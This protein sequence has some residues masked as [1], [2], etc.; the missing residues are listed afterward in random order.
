MPNP[1]V[2]LT[3]AIAQ[4]HDRIIYGEVVAPAPPLATSPLFISMPDWSADYYFEVP[5]WPM[6]HGAALPAVGAAVVLVRDSRGF[7]R[8]VWWDGTTTSAAATAPAP[9]G[10]AAKDTAAINALLATGAR[11]VLQPGTYQT[12]ASLAMTSHSSLIG[13]GRNATT[14]KKNGNYPT[15]TVYGATSVTNHCAFVGISDLTLDGNGSA[16]TGPH[17]DCVY[18]DNVIVERMELVSN[19]D[20][21]IDMVELW[22][23]H[24]NDIVCDACN[25]TSA[26]A[27]H[28]RSSRAASGFG[29]SGDTTNVIRFTNIRCESWRNGGI[30]V[31]AGTGGASPNQ[32]WFSKVKCE[33]YFLRGA[34]IL[35]AGGNSVH[36]KD[37]Y[38]FMGGF[39]SGFSTAQA[40][41]SN[42]GAGFA[43]SLR[44]CHIGNG[45][46]ATI[47][48]GVYTWSAG[49]LVYDNVV[50]QY[51]TAPT[52][53]YHLNLAGGGVHHFSSIYCTGATPVFISTGAQVAGEISSNSTSGPITTTETPIK[54][55]YVMGGQMF[56]RMSFRITAYGYVSASAAGTIQ[57]AIRVGTTGTTSDALV[58][59]TPATGSV[60]T[61]VGWHADGV[62]TCRA[63]GSS[64]TMIGNISIVVNTAAGV[65]VNTATI[66]VDTTAD[67]QIGFTVVGG[68]TSPSISVTNCVIERIQTL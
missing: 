30:T 57:A 27:I 59:Q 67:Q 25:S 52:T 53:G 64:G 18:A 7:L 61:Q 23:S 24:F 48:E 36:F 51:N 65:S 26:P 54:S 43:L 20:S 12:N 17:I 37:V 10:S 39:D 28:V 13:A 63:A 19:N 45:S 5:T 41:F 6:V 50:G 21:G 9:S 66:A 42:T 35:V 46:V 29:S 34:A 56:S 3:P 47:E 44:D 15:V 8:C 62:L 4:E 14:I 38:L 16:Y 32:I 31:E 1:L 60:T 58:A 49:N 11:V 33:S 2:L 22:D 55:L 40:A 68:G